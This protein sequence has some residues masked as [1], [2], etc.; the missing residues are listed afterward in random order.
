VTSADQLCALNQVLYDAAQ[1]CS[2]QVF[3]LKLTCSHS[4]TGTSPVAAAETAARYDD[5]KL[6]KDSSSDHHTSPSTLSNNNNNNNNNDN[7]YGAVIIA[8]SHCESSP[9]S[10]DEYGTAPSSRRPWLRPG[11]T[12]RAASPPV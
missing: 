12:S 3:T 11:Q 7:V 9:G 4:T 5:S 6:E 10:C 2:R 8:Q 1:H